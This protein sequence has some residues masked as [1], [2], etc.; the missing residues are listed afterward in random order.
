MRTKIVQ[1]IIDCY[2][3]KPTVDSNI[4]GY[5]YITKGDNHGTEFI[6]TG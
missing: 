5:L 3:S 6:E 1:M 2:H 4:R